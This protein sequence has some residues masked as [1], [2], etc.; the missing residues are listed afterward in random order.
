ME[1][2]H[3]Q[4]E[5]YSP[6]SSYFNQIRQKKKRSKVQRKRDKFFGLKK[7]QDKDDI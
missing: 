6:D 3:M 5:K 2:Y 7:K 4:T 1:E